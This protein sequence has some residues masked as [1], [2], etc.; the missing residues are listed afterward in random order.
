MPALKEA[1]KRALIAQRINTSINKPT[2]KEANN[3]GLI[4]QRI[5]ATIK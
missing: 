1:N 4:M 2:L 3:R 5:N